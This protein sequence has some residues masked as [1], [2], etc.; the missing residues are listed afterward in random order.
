MFDAILYNIQIKSD[1]L[2]LEE[3]VNEIF[4]RNIKFRVSENSLIKIFQFVM[5]TSSIRSLTLVLIY[6]KKKLHH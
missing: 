5:L 3:S 1:I 4:F 6:L 2:H